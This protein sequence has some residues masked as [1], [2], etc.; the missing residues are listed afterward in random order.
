MTAT[1]LLT[2]LIVVATPGTG[3]LYTIAAG[4]ARGGRASLV[5]AFGCT[6]QGT[7]DGPPGLVDRTQPG[8][9]GPQQHPCR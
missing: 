4:L 9:T 8:V 1:F 5:A 2:S 6:L 3:A 7:S